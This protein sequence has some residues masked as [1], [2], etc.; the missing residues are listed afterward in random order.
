MKPNGIL[1][2]WTSGPHGPGQFYFT[3]H[4]FGLNDT[5]GH[6]QDGDTWN[7]IVVSEP[8]FFKSRI[9]QTNVH[10]FYRLGEPLK[11]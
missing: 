9:V 7:M 11:D 4:I 1:E 6:V 8:P 5:Y 3:G 2:N 10:N